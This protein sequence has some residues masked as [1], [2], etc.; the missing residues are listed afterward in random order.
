MKWHR[1]LSSRV[2]KLLTMAIASAPSE[3]AR[4]PPPSSAHTLIASAKNGARSTGTIGPNVACLRGF[5]DTLS[6]KGSI[7]GGYFAAQ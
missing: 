7:A 6:A 2:M 4:G 3:T 5:W 1:A